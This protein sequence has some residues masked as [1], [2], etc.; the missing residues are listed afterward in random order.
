MF[1]KQ[2]STGNLDN[3]LGSNSYHGLQP[4][5]AISLKPPGPI[6]LCFQ[7]TRTSRGSR[8]YTF[9]H[10]QHFKHLLHWG[11]MASVV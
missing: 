9:K 6:N 7:N 11:I 3:Q 1:S 4:C 2:V 5:C 8:S 10:T